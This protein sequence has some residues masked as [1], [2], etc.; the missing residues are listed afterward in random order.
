MTSSGFAEGLSVRS[1]FAQMPD[2][3]LPYISRS[4]RLDMMDFIDSGMKA[5]VLNAFGDTLR[6]DVLTDDYLHVVLSEASTLELK[7]MDDMVCVVITYGKKLKTSRVLFYNA[8][9]EELY[10]NIEGLQPY[11]WCSLS[12]ESKDMTIYTYDYDLSEREGVVP[13]VTS[14]TIA[15]PHSSRP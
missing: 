7:A 8:N 1:V 11:T 10:I 4:N 3:L 9:W 2:S 14:R 6:M 12:P 15:A 13:I 5:E